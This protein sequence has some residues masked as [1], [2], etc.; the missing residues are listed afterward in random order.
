M[1]SDE[2][3]IV[4]PRVK[5]VV[6]ALLLVGV[7]FAAHATAA[8]PL[9][10]WN[11][12]SAR[13]AILEFVTRTTTPGS[14]DFLEP[15]ARI[16][17][18]DNDGTL[19]PETPLPFQ[20]QFVLDELQ[21]LR[22]DHPEWEENPAITAALAGDVAS[23]LRSGSGQGAMLLEA[24]HAGLTVDAFNDRVRR[25]LDTARHP[26]WKRPYSDL[27]YQPMLEVLD[28][29]RDHGFTPF[30][31][32]GGG[33]DFMRVWAEEVYGIP[34][35]QVIGSYG[36][37]R[38]ELRDVRPVLV[39]EGGIELIDDREGKPVG[40]HRFIGRRPVACFG[41]SDGDQAMLEWTTI[42]HEPSF[43]LIVHHTD[44][45]RESAYDSDPKG[46]GK[47]VTALEAAPR[48]GWVVVNMARDWKVVFKPLEG[49]PQR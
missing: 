5:S 35:S 2:R 36:K 10:S 45:V 24:T 19:W 39:K 27:A 14:P 1:R 32:S 29:L 26:V 11:D 28:L 13:K 34:P 8:E 20:A 40:I 47:L 48:R 49:A 16:A 33:A 31:V 30:I 44:A 42:D 23:V 17:V 37:V 18:F 15:A 25:W 22:G 38:Y 9:P 43:G 7:V 41:N 21:R 12:G 3:S 46:T 4:R 6:L